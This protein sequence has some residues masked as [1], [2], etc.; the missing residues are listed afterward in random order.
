MVSGHPQ[1]ND[2]PT[3][4]QSEADTEPFVD[5]A[6]AFVRRHRLHDEADILAA[7]GLGGAA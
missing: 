5:R 3:T 1:T 6:T 4:A 7:L 2:F